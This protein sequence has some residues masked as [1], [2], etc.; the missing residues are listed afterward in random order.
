M[1]GACVGAHATAGL[2]GWLSCEQRV[3]SGAVGSSTLVDR[4]ALKTG[5][6]CSLA[7]LRVVILRRQLPAAS[8]L[9]DMRPQVAHLPEVGPVQV[10]SCALAPCQSL[11]RIKSCDVWACDWAAL[12]CPLVGAS[13]ERAVCAVGSAAGSCALIVARLFPWQWLLV[14]TVDG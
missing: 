10:L 5:A 3:A 2:A 1:F 7:P 4:P 14:S 9:T 11:S 12:F 13:F 8:L 6:A